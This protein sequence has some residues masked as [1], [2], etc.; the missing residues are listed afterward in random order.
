MADDT[1]PLVSKDGV[2]TLEFLGSIG[3]FVLL[4]RVGLESDLPSLVKKLPRSIPVWLG[5]IFLSGVPAYFLCDYYFGLELVPSLF[6]SVALTATSVGISADIWRESSALNTPNGETF[7]DVAELD[8]LSGIALLALL[9][10]IAPLLKAGT[11]DHLL[12]VT[13]TTLGVFAI[14]LIGVLVACYFIAKYGE[15][16]LSQLL[17]KTSDPDSILILV[18]TG[19]IFATLAALMGFSLAIGALFAGLIF[20]RDPKAVK[21]E[22]GFLP[23]NS[24][25][26]PFFFVLIGFEID[27]NSL[28][29]AL[30]LGGALLIVAILGKVIGA[31]GPALMFSGWAGAALIGV[32]MVPRAEIAM[33]IVQQGRELGD[34]AV[35]PEVYSSIMLVSL[36]TCMISPFLIR[37]LI[38]NY[39]H[40]TG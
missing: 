17:R 10:A 21:L 34:W 24:F 32:S 25:F 19:I 18:G 15:R 6:V 31:G 23:L 20:S 9:L 29:S 36:V 14:K 11:N 37:W 12:Q 5:D 13:V 26:A 39:P 33:V 22:S 8:D 30:S 7:I 40:S 35:P 4:F 1:W 2:A 38:R 3:L 28:Q 16:H 27:P